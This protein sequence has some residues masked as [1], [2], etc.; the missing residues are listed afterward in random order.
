MPPSSVRYRMTRLS[1]GVGAGIALCGIAAATR[2]A[3]AGYFSWTAGALSDLGVAAAGAAA[4]VFNGSLVVGGIVG[5]PY[6]TALHAAVR[7]DEDGAELGDGSEGLTIPGVSGVAALYAFAL[8]GMTLV[9][10]FPAGT[11]MHVPAAV[12]FFLG[13]TAAMAV[14]G[15]TRR[16][17][18]TGRASLAL[19][20]VVTVVW[21]SWPAIG[22]AGVA[23]PEAVGAVAFAVWV[24]GVGPAPVR[25][26]RR[27][28]Q[29]RSDR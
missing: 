21:A 17:R 10:L 15:W 28:G 9:G 1:G 8:V 27:D 11:A 5:L 6:A 16:T 25:E 14:D 18:P 3:P 2:L 7:D 29:G 26:V 19:A 4:P 12:G 22:T 20:A 23:I 24:V 13:A